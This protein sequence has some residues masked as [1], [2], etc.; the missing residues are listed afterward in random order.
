M[1]RCSPRAR[2]RRPRRGDTSML[3]HRRGHPEWFDASQTPAT[4][5][6]DLGR[7][8]E[9]SD[10]VCPA[11]RIQPS[12]HSSGRGRCATL[13]PH[14]STAFARSASSS[15]VGKQWRE[16]GDV[17]QVRIGGARSSSRCTQTRWSMSTS[18][19]GSNYD[20][21]GSYDG[22]RKYLL[23]EGLVASTGELWRRQR[24]PDGP[25]LHPQG[26]AGYAELMLR[27]GARLVERW[28]RA[29]QRAPRWRS[30]TR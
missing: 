9:R 30:P 23:G 24:K 21:R 11:D 2:A 5:R 25:V 7:A 13:P 4:H 6:I 1:V 8:P 18:A 19:S 12:S 26:R 3:T 16:H 14:S 29:R 27:D 10:E 15:I 20:K 22:V 28:Q 17:F